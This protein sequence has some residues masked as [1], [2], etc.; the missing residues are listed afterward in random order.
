MLDA[1]LHD[2]QARLSRIP[3]TKH[4]LTGL[5]V[6]PFTI[7]DNYDDIMDKTLTPNVENVKKEEYLTD[8]NKHLQKIDL[9]ENHNTEVNEYNCK[10]NIKSLGALK[11]FINDLGTFL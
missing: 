2:A 5:T 6:V 8:F 9:L 1:L 11:K 4:Q 7:H 3:Y 10:R